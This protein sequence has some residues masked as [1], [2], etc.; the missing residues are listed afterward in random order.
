ML[1][2]HGKHNGNQLRSEITNLAKKCWGFIKSMKVV[3][4]DQGSQGKP[5]TGGPGRVC[6]LES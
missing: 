1:D 6:P 5:Q 4:R 2:K 3:L